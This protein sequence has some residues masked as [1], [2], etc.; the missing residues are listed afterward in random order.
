MRR[1]AGSAVRGVIQVP[2]SIINDIISTHDSSDIDHDELAAKVK[3]KLHGY[4]VDK[5]GLTVGSARGR[6][7]DSPDLES[8]LGEHN[9]PQV[10]LHSAGVAHPRD[11]ED[12]PVRLFDWKHHGDAFHGGNLAWRK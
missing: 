5:R 7:G 1:N 8:A 4:I 10:T 2:S 9:A 12:G 6:A 3:D 11:N